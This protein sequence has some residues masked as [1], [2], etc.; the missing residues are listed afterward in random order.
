M[1]DRSKATE[2]ELIEDLNCLGGLQRTQDEP[3]AIKRSLGF[4]YSFDL[5]QDTKL[6]EGSTVFVAQELSIRL[7]IEE[8]DAE[9]RV[10]LK[11]S[12]AALNKLEA[13]QL[14]EPP[15]SH[16]PPTR[17]AELFVR[18]Y[19]TSGHRKQTPACLY[20]AQQHHQTAFK[21]WMPP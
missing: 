4:W 11:I 3:Q 17:P 6:R 8:F 9:G 18:C 5:G 12:Q 13:G 15:A 10:L 16:H 1:F 7:T 2:A 19:Q 21:R 20:T 14:P